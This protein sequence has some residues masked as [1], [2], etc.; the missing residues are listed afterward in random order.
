[1]GNS[2][3]TKTQE[4]FQVA[5]FYSFIPLP[6]ETI[7]LLL[8]DLPELAH[9]HN[10]LGSVLVASEGINGTIC[11]SKEGVIIFIDYLKTLLKVD[12]LDVKYSFTPNQAFRR[13]KSRRKTEIVTM[14]IPNVNPLLMAGE[15]I[16]PLDWNSLI[17]DEETLLIDTR[18]QYEVAIGTFEGAI[19]PNTKCFRDFP[20]WV[21]QKLLPL[22]E[23]RQPK[24][25]AMFCTGGIRCEKATSLLQ[26]KGIN[27]VCHLKGGILNYLEK[28][29]DKDSRWKGEC[30]VFDQRVAVN[31]N[32]EP[33][34]HS[35]CH[36]R[37]MPLSPEDRQMPSYVRGVQCPHCIDLFNQRD[38]ERFAERQ[39]QMDV[40]QETS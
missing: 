26:K 8:S 17:E 30:F 34:I 25:V 9:E 4:G 38:R 23:A 39:R 19:N 37:G 21:E 29:P 35:L 7:S 24:K 33:G 28:V 10:L 3:R 16:D 32:L 2:S 40:N 12:L 22:L 1:M 20:H 31:Q 13:F 11:G 15:Y 36:A 27:G 14:G 5:A 18:N 6:V